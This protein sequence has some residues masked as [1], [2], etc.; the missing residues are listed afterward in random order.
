MKVDGSDFII[1]V[2]GW[3][4]GLLG[5][6]II[7]RITTASKR[8]DLHSIISSELR[9]TK[10]RLITMGYLLK[11]KVGGF[12]V[13]FLEQMR[14]ELNEYKGYERLDEIRKATNAQDYTN[15]ELMPNMVNA[16]NSKADGGS[17]SLKMISMNV[18][19]ANM[20]NLYMFPDEM[21]ARLIEIKYAM[22][23]ISQEIESARE[24]IMLT[25]TRIS[26]QNHEI[27][28]TEIQNKYRYIADMSDR[29][30]RRINEFLKSKL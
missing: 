28:S 5:P 16:F 18:L 29:A 12:T 4:L 27:A 1:L 15:P 2:L 21:R 7:D 30:V 8:K 11:C 9:D 13:E 20:S 24:F 10:I 14:V 19:A 17:I 3:L 22:D 25:F 26:D 23:A 6:A